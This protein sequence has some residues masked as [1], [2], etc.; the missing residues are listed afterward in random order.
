MKNKQILCCILGSLILALLSSN[1]F[2]NARFGIFGGTELGWMIESLTI[3]ISL[4][5]YILLT[6]FSSVLIIRNIKLKD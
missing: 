4:I 1:I 6:V 3:M 2:E 5:G